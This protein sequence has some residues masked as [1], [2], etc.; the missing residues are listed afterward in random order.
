M[1]Y[2]RADEPVAIHVYEALTGA[3][4]DVWLDR[5]K[6]R[7]RIDWWEGVRSAID[8]CAGVLLVVSDDSSRSISCSREVAYAL[9]RGK[10]IVR[11]GV[12]PAA[13]HKD[14]QSA[15]TDKS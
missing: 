7:P 10:P 13:G 2:A 12:E 1:S 11:I 8:Q 15:D 6:L 5:A 9:E 3:G 14:W 4:R